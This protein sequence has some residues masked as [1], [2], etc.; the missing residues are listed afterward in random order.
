MELH[1]NKLMRRAKWLI[2]TPD[3]SWANRIRISRIGPTLKDFWPFYIDVNAKKHSKNHAKDMLLN[4]TLEVCPERG[5][6]LF[7]VSNYPGIPRL[8]SA[9]LLADRSFEPDS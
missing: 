8:H 6:T 2:E 4:V 7:F 5:A 1:D 9:R 3:L